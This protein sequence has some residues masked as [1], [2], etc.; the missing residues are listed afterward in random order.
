MGLHRGDTE[1][2]RNTRRRKSQERENGGS[3]GESFGVI[4]SPR[5]KITRS[6]LRVA[7][8]STLTPMTPPAK[9]RRFRVA[10][11]FPGELRWRVEKIAEALAVPLRRERILYDKWYAAEFTR[12]RLDIYLS[13]LYHN[14]SD[15][16]AVF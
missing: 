13:D 14:N 2:R 12:P 6:H 4:L 15:L 10:L 1:T 11:S 3:G 5:A 8:D 16:I 9:S 7:A